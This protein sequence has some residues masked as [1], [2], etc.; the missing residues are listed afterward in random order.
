MAER[1]ALGPAQRE[2]PPMKPEDL[3]IISSC[4]RCFGV[5]WPHYTIFAAICQLR[6]FVTNFHT[7]V[8]LLS[9]WK[10]CCSCKEERI[11]KEKEEERLRLELE[12][13]K[14][15]EEE[16]L[17]KEKEE[18]ARKEKERKRIENLKKK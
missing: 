16:K 10:V 17:R 2:C 1:K 11:R 4:S 13:K 18:L 9:Q 5:D 12:E 14:R 15:I 3:V 7:T 6:F 8:N